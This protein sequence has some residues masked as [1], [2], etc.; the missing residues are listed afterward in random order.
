LEYQQS[1]EPSGLGSDVA[2]FVLESNELMPETHVMWLL[3]RDLVVL[4]SID[5]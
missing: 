2:S 5:L 3:A 1:N 4:Q